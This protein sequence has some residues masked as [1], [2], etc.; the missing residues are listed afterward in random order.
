MVGPGSPNT[1]LTST[2]T[3]PSPRIRSSSSLCSGS[4][5]VT[6]AALASIARPLR[7]CATSLPPKLLLPLH[8]SV[9]TSRAA[10][11][12]A[13]LQSTPAQTSESF[14]S[15]IKTSESL[16]CSRSSFTAPAAGPPPTNGRPTTTSMPP[17]SASPEPP[18]P[19]PM[20]I[21]E[22]MAALRG[23]GLNTGGDEPV[24][25][26]SPANR[27]GSVQ[28]GG[29]PKQSA[30]P[31]TGSAAAAATT[32]PAPT[33]NG[34]GSLREAGGLSRPSS[35]RGRKR[36]EVVERLER[37][38]MDPPPSEQSSAASASPSPAK[39]PSPMPV[40]AAPLPS[41][42][43]LQPTPAP[44]PVVAPAQPLPPPDV[45]ISSPSPVPPPASVP[46]KSADAVP[47][48]AVA[49]PSAVPS[50]ISHGYS[51]SVPSARSASPSRASPTK[52]PKPP[53]LSIQSTTAVSSSFD[54]SLAS[55]PEQLGLG[56][57][58]STNGGSPAAQ[59]PRRR[60]APVE[61]DDFSPSR[62]GHFPSITEFESSTTTFDE[63]RGV[64]TPV[65]E[66]APSLTFPSLPSVPLSLPGSAPSTTR[67]LP[68]PP[69]PPPGGAFQTKPQTTGSSVSSF[70]SALSAPPLASPT[71]QTAPN[72]IPA[73]AAAAARPVQQP[74]AA[75]QPVDFP[76]ANTIF[77]ALLRQY[78][79]L[80]VELLLLDVRPPQAW[81]SRIT[82]TSTG[83]GQADCVCIPPA[84]LSSTLSSQQLADG[85]PRTS[86]FHNRHLY[87]LVVIYDGAST[88]WA[89]PG[90][91]GAQAVNR[92]VYERE[93][94]GKMLKRAPV[95]L[96]GGWEAWRAAESG[97]TGTKQALMSP[98]L[99]RTAEMN[100]LGGSRETSPAAK[101]SY[102]P[103]VRSR[104]SGVHARDRELT[105]FFASLDSAD[106]A[107][108]SGG[109]AGLLVA[110]RQC[111]ACLR[112]ARP[113]V[114]DSRPG[115][116]L[117]QPLGTDDSP[118]RPGLARIPELAPTVRVRRPDE[119]LHG[120]PR[121]LRLA[122][123]PALE[124]WRRARQQR[125]RRRRAAAWA[126]D[127]L[128]DAVAL[129]VVL[130]RPP[131]SA[132][133]AASQ[134]EHV[135]LAP[136]LVGDIVPAAA[137]AGRRDATARAQCLPRSTR[138][139]RQLELPDAE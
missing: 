137:A 35:G 46:E 100:G 36:D 12:G 45:E 120:L 61:D 3:G 74:P 32:T 68:S 13:S 17:P 10:D 63:P 27:R 76:L 138:P 16:L 39:L 29:P 94:G 126:V 42:V 97:T 128:S 11:A 31:S 33:L 105:G 132:G 2:P 26:G 37:L 56:L 52:P 19:A 34:S 83:G 110:K 1:S 48:P 135:N 4:S 129:V 99:G 130:A 71:F 119:R 50:R 22:R 95:L 116:V 90:A 84:L 7:A 72:G 59:S 24:M 118:A 96:V 70:Q 75:D 18:S 122:D 113:T 44:P 57:N 106:S 117:V 66:D 121:Q 78:L 21:K 109:S 86:P 60:P 47:E 134:V 111:S 51:A 40:S 136:A 69:L 102:F 30:G 58:S 79:T 114:F 91:E 23:A 49:P 133:R 85:L 73:D 54:P 9:S 88:G 87:D 124:Q 67:P 127:R 15:R 92:A 115:L 20:S 101:P 14:K 8:L 65:G 43:P 62:F 55:A 38:A 25:Q 5:Y 53:A 89:A 108:A 28:L 103:L 104:T 80:P 125:T 139:E 64:S 81:S 112:L 41:S 93:F 82:P 98:G 131:T 123:E 107:D 6:S 77:P